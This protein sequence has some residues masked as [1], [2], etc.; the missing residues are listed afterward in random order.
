M[1]RS[2]VPIETEKQRRSRK[3]RTLR[4]HC[5]WW[6]TDSRRRRWYLFLLSA[7]GRWRWG[8]RERG[9]E[10]ECHTSN[11][12]FSAIIL[13]IPIPTPSITANRIAHPIAEFLAA[14]NP[15][16]IA[17]EPPVRNPAPTTT[18]SALSSIFLPISCA[19][20]CGGGKHILAFHGSSFF[21]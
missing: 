12:V 15:P 3:H 20:L 19:L 21:R 6:R 14:L 4:V 1:W 8:R 10:Q 18:P 13:C 11:R 9:G 7:Q 17:N 16:R 2:G 5:C